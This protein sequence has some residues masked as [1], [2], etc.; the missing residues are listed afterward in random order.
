M[1]RII[2]LFLCVT[3][4]VPLVPLECIASAVTYL[5]DNSE[6]VQNRVVK[7]YPAYGFTFC[8]AESDEYIVESQSISSFKYALKEMDGVEWGTI[9]FGTQIVYGNLLYCKVSD[10]RSGVERKHYI[11]IN[12]LD[13]EIIYSS[14]EE[15]TIKTFK[16]KKYKPLDAPG[17]LLY[18]GTTSNQLN[19]LNGTFALCDY[20]EAYSPLIA[21]QHD[22]VY[23]IV[24]TDTGDYFPYGF[25]QFNKDAIIDG[26]LIGIYGDYT[27]AREMTLVGA[28]GSALLQHCKDIS[29]IDDQYLLVRDGYSKA[30]VYSYD[31][32]VVLPCAYRHIS[33]FNGD[34]AVVTGSKT[35]SGG[36]IFFEYMVDQTGK[37]LCD[38]EKY[39]AIS[40]FSDGVAIGYRPIY[41][42]SEYTGDSGYYYGT[43]DLL[44]ENGEVLDLAKNYGGEYAEILCINN[45]T[46]VNYA[47]QIEYWPEKTQY[48]SA[49]LK[50]RQ[51]QFISNAL[52]G[53]NKGGTNFDSSSIAVRIASYTEGN[54]G[55]YPANV[56]YTLHFEGFVDRFGDSIKDL[57][58]Q[59]QVSAMWNGFSLVRNRLD[60]KEYFISKDGAIIS[61][62]DVQYARAIRGN[63]L[64]LEN[65][66][67]SG[68]PKTCIVDTAGTVVWS[69]ENEVRLLSVLPNHLALW[70]DM[71]PE[72]KCGLFSLTRK[73]F[74]GYV[75]K[76]IL[77][78]GKATINTDLVGVKN[79]DE[80]YSVIDRDN[81][82]II[83]ELK[84]EP[85]LTS[86]GK[87]YGTTGET[88]SLPNNWNRFG[89]P[90]Q[91][92]NT[93][94]TPTWIDNL[95][96]Y[97]RLSF[98]WLSTNNI[99][100]GFV[101]LSDRYAG[102]ATEDGR[103]LIDP[104]YR[105][106]IDLGNGY[107]YAEDEEE[108]TYLVSL[109]SGT[110]IAAI[111]ES[112]YRL[113]SSE[114][115]T[116]GTVS[117]QMRLG[118]DFDLDAYGY[119]RVFR[120]TN[121]KAHSSRLRM[122][123][124]TDSVGIGQNS[125]LSA[126]YQI[127]TPMTYD[128]AA[129]WRSSNDAIISVAASP[130]HR[131]KL[132]AQITGQAPG[133]AVI[134][135]ELENGDTASVEITVN[136]T[137][138][139]LIEMFPAY[140]QSSSF[141]Q[142]MEKAQGAYS[143]ILQQR[144][145]KR[146]YVASYFTALKAG[147]S[148]LVHYADWLPGLKD[149]QEAFPFA[150]ISL[151]SHYLLSATQLLVEELDQNDKICTD[152]VDDL[153]KKW[154]HVKNGVDISTK[155]AEEEFVGEITV[156]TGFLRDDIEEITKYAKDKVKIADKTLTVA[157]I[158]LN[159]MCIKQLE[160]ELVQKLRAMQTPGSDLEIGLSKLEYKMKTN[161]VS[162][163]TANYLKDEFVKDIVGECLK[164][165]Y[166]ALG[167]SGLSSTL[168]KIAVSTIVKIY[169]SS[170][171]AFADSV[172]ETWFLSSFASRLY[173]QFHTA[174]IALQAKQNGAPLSGVSVPTYQE[175]RFIY[176]AY[177][178]ATK[179]ALRSAASITNDQEGF[180]KNEA[181]A[182]AA[183][184]DLYTFDRYMSLCKKELSG[185]YL[186]HFDISE[187]KELAVVVGYYTE[188]A[189]PMSQA[190][191][192]S[193]VEYSISASAPRLYA[194]DVV[195]I[196]QRYGTTQV[197]AIGEKAFSNNTQ[198]RGVILPDSITQIR[199]QAFMGC[200]NLE[201]VI[202][203]NNVTEIGN[204]AFSGC[205]NLKNII[206]PNSVTTLGTSAFSDCSSL[207][208]IQIPETLSDIPCDTFFGA[209]QLKHITVLG[210]NTTIA[211]SAL[212]ANEGLEIAALP[213]SAVAEYVQ[214]KGYTYVA[215]NYALSS[216][217]VVVPP[218]SNEVQLY[219]S[220]D[221]SGMT[222]QATYADGSTKRVDK[223][224][225]VCADTSHAGDITAVI[226][227]E[228]LSIEYPITVIPGEVTWKALK[229]NQRGILCGSVFNG[230]ENTKR[231]LLVLAAYTSEGMELDAHCEVVE[232]D[233]GK[234]A[235]FT[236]YVENATYYK[237]FLLNENITPWLTETV[238]LG[239][240]KKI[241][242]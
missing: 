192:R 72:S 136:V 225:E 26:T 18:Y 128:G 162:D 232:I 234:T 78:Y 31:G 99:E 188:E 52:A 176:E 228:N 122:I 147:P 85:Y 212:P 15:V 152:I 239:A 190:N 75:F 50:G 51:S 214:K 221:F 124:S 129:V 169:Q 108:N 12:G 201:T 137:D 187:G 132:S 241:F 202:L 82:I 173:G 29:Y 138:E 102:Y 79:S 236:W 211:S 178:A 66:S 21:I 208:E 217:E 154:K 140:L 3:L 24:N 119:T 33:Y 27:G 6:Q 60:N 41:G 199:S 238:M 133:K 153:S 111:A 121:L 226:S 70:D 106:I 83:S 177:I 104:Q 237:V 57:T 139:N 47:S 116:S 34:V 185:D 19:G 117:L 40:N 13:G 229:C 96:Y 97:T 62:K 166:G 150:D 120:F 90:V 227:Y 10:S 193:A 54:E 161:L 16:P 210:A 110:Q 4:I 23:D 159:V 17:A 127:N 80:S 131:G 56:N 65:S 42:H 215:L 168:G 174:S 155:A 61:A 175:Y 222:L 49:Y 91:C 218:L 94:G 44:Y 157:D 20:R 145:G 73:E 172:S 69:S 89:Y 95:Y 87:I 77:T 148:M 55:G 101:I 9:S 2:S 130:E 143:D 68:V 207:Q 67:V 125:V 39:T 206:L 149:L 36:N 146:D 43:C 64:F 204:S 160:L 216:L 45:S 224:W 181:L 200:T 37:P 165:G 233:I 167:I 203:G 186:R 205:K 220:P 98:D 14:E 213:G 28:D 84:G 126:S 58:D 100:D 46:L 63:F 189:E 196:P 219:H 151:E 240:E 179:A 113:L 223:A 209:D 38:T 48:C 230:A 134:S 109:G 231:G 93:D 142:L 198:I 32:Q 92:F 163:V 8:S 88:V 183:Q 194:D 195:V 25:D 11:L 1:K 107:A 242:P 197:T 135:V 81:N 76:N 105:K 156:A 141:D 86:S 114:S 22:G 235:D 123:S 7:D 5:S 103:I 53:K 59:Y 35:L 180:L 170:G 112:G 74:T 182:Y 184:L 118:Y 144:S 158:V 191:S 171:E 71:Q 164:K 30:G 115:T